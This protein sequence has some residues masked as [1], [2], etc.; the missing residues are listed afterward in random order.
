M[1]GILQT[2]RNEVNALRS[3]IHKLLLDMVS[4]RGEVPPAEI[5][6]ELNSI[7]EKA[8]KIFMK[9]MS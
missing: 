9:G 2:R 7:V 5:M 3:G 8:D 6:R 4:H 1:T